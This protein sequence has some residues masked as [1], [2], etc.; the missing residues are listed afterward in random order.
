[1]PRHSTPYWPEHRDVPDAVD[2][3]GSAAAELVQ[4]RGELG[5]VG[6]VAHEDRGHA[7]PEP[8]A[9]GPRGGGAKDQPRILVVDLVGAVAGVKAELVSAPDR[10]QELIGRLL[11]KHLKARQHEP[12]LTRMAYGVAA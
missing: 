1:M 11:R 4:G 8:D 9:L 10:V 6:G 12:T 2:D 3:L 5:D 7:R